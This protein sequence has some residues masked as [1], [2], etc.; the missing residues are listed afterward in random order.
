L[1]RSRDNRL[2]RSASTFG[3]RQGLEKGNKKQEAGRKKTTRLLE[4][5]RGRISWG[6]KLEKA[7]CDIPEGSKGLSEKATTSWRVKL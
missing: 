7:D 2:I 6:A 3:K 1:P 4:T 5:N